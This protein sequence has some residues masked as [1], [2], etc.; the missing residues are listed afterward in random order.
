[1]VEII[2]FS[3]V[4]IRISIE[5]SPE[6]DFRILPKIL[7]AGRPPETTIAERVRICLCICS[8]KTVIVKQLLKRLYT[9]F[10][11]LFRAFAKITSLIALRNSL[12]ITR[13]FFT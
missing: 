8:T 2:I 7:V 9:R 4:Y 6:I 12:D 5:V 11:F 3:A 13:V 10:R 1:M